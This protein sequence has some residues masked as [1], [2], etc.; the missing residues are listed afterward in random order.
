MKPAAQVASHVPLLLEVYRSGPQGVSLA[1]QHLNVVGALLG[2]VMLWV[3]P[4]VSSAV[5]LI[6]LNSLLQA[7]TMY[8]LVAWMATTGGRGGG[9]IRHAE[10]AHM[11]H[12][13]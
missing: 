7:L 4:P 3:L 6:Y 10:P 11:S 1:T 9:L 12:R 5:W 2:F 13:L 8:G